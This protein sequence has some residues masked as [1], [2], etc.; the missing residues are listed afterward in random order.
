MSN[1]DNILVVIPAR[2]GSKGIPRKNVRNLGGKPL[3]YYSITSALKLGENVDV[4]VSSDDDEILTL[5]KNFGAQIHK[6]DPKLAEDATTLDPVIH[7]CY[8]FA[9]NEHGK[10]YKYIITLQPTSPLL[11]TSSIKAAIQYMDKNPSIETTL[12]AVN[13]THLTW[14]KEDNTFKPNYKARLNRQYLNPVYKETGGFFITRSSIITENNRIGQQVH[15]YEL[16][17]GEN[18][19]IDNFHDWALCEYILRKKKSAFR[20][21]GKSRYWPWSCHEHLEYRQRYFRA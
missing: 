14:N 17:E 20:C 18:I 6:R 2:G 11:K 5:S 7:A 8:Q 15:L 16:G 3:I 21:T 12:S 4:Y 1:S 9:M 19:D 10:T 13:D